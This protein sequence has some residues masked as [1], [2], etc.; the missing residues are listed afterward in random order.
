MNDDLVLLVADEVIGM[1]IIILLLLQCMV[2]VVL[3]LR[4]NLLVI[5]DRV[6]ILTR[7]E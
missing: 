1:Y 2:E 4:D 3:Y 7:V 6:V 5:L